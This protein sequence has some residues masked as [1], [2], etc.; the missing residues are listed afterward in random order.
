VAIRQL[1]VVK[2]KKANYTAQVIFNR[3][4]M[5]RSFPLNGRLICA[6]CFSILIFF[7]DGCKKKPAPPPPPEVQV[8]TI[9]PTNVPIFEEWIGTL[10]GFVNAQIHAQVTGYLLTQ[11][12]GEG[13]EVRKGDLLFQIDPRPFQ[14]TLDQAQAKLAQDQAQAGK[15]ELD[16]KRYTPL[17]E[18]Q[19]ISQEE[20]DNAVQANIG[21]KAQVKADEAAIENAQLNL[22]FTRIT[23]PVD[24]LAGA[25]LAQ[26]GDLV[27]QSSS[28]L[29]TVSTINPIKV[30]FQV[31]EQSYL[32]FWRRFIGVTN[33][34]K[35][36]PLQLI[37]SD[38]SVYPEKGKFFYA[39]RQVNPNTGTL[40][41]VG[42]FPN[43]N[44]ILRPGQYGRVRAQTQT[45][46]NALIVPQR[47][48]AELQGTYQ[49]AVVGE[50][51]SVHLQSVKVGEQVGAN[52]II[53]SGLKPGDRVVV[54]GT[55]KAKDGA[56][57][58]PKPFGTETNQ[59]DQTE[60]QTNQS[61]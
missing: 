8:I 35:N 49:V 28:V 54:E 39:D 60:T 20:L 21:A 55:Q 5:R 16:V 10:D 1:Q 3:D 4:C 40:Q 50:T 23:S 17:A 24:G 29:T 43:V 52:W 11:N 9:A 53:E 59:T 51:N 38:G 61:K 46:T 41:I 57:V 42:L 34:A 56:V 22:G 47:A 25:A 27:G 13:S 37:F 32:T 7:A 36:S 30:Y 18:E 58:N 2:D 44:F 26:I 15:T 12:Y 31:S 19:A 6:L 33:E 48:V 14:A 45:M